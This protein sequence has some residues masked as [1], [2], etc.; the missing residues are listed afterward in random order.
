[1]LLRPRFQPLRLGL[2]YYTPV[3]SRVPTPPRPQLRKRVNQADVDNQPV[4]SGASAARQLGT[5]VSPVPTTPIPQALANLLSEPTLVIERQL[6]MMNVF[7]GYEQANRYTIYNPSGQVLGYMEEDDLSFFKMISRQFYRLH[8]PF[9]VNVYDASGQHAMTIRRPFS[10]IN[11]HIRCLLPGYDGNSTEGLIGESRQEWHLWRRRYNLYLFN[12]QQAEMEQ[13]GRVDAPF[14]SF[15]FPIQSQ[16]GGI[17][18]AVDRNWVGLAREMF[19]DTGVYVLRTD[20][21][22]L[23]EVGYPGSSSPLSLEQRA[24]SLATAVSIDFDYFSRH[25]NRSNV[26]YYE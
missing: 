21:A 20:A 26:A 19:T 23:N 6:E 1:M 25:S 15:A 22:S 2:R 12:R 14:L 11:S 4:I 5:P 8:R 3:R 7:L 9:T 16:D 13:F 17:V 10:F 18:G 24:V